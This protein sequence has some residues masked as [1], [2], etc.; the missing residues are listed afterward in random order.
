MVGHRSRSAAARAAG[1]SH[2]KCS[3]PASSSSA[4]RLDALPIPAASLAAQIPE[5]SCAGVAMARSEATGLHH[6]AL[7]SL[8][9][10]V[11]AEQ[12][13]HEC[14][15]REDLAPRHR[16]Q[17]NSVDC[18]SK[19]EVGAFFGGLKK[20]TFWP[21]P[22]TV[23]LG[24]EFC[25]LLPVSALSTKFSLWAVPRPVRCAPRSLGAAEPAPEDLR[26]RGR[27][28][29]SAWEAATCRPLQLPPGVME[30]ALRQDVS[31]R[32]PNNASRDDDPDDIVERS[33]DG[34]YARVR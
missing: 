29:L 25:L 17:T 24:L 33:P 10:I 3:V 9:P 6:G 26:V 28:G 20:K 4:S 5:A 13:R 22:P 2:A 16:R 7:S 12:G 18:W 21:P 15:K 23:E 27:G 30:G 1:A 32:G 14:G 34:R 31:E 8:P 19:K 11:A